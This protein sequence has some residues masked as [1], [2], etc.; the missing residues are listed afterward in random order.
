MLLHQPTVDALIDSMTPSADEVQSRKDVLEFSEQDSLLLKELGPL[1]APLESAF[2]DSLSQHLDSHPEMAATLSNPEQLSQ[3]KQKQQEYFKK[4]F[5]GDYGPD[6]IKSRL[7]VGVSYQQIG[8]EPRW[9]LGAYNKY[10]SLVLPEVMRLVGNDAE[11]FLAYSKAITKIAMFDSELSLSAYFHADHEMLRLLAQVFESNLEAVIIADVKG[12][13]LHVNKSVAKITG[14]ASD[15]LIGTP[16]QNLLA[17]LEPTLYQDLW[18]TV[19]GGGQWQG[20]IWLKNKQG[21]D[22]LAWMNMNAVKDAA[23]KVT[24]VIAEFSDITA[25][26]QTQ[27]ALAQRTEELANSNRELE[28]FAYVASHDLQEPLRM[29]ASYTQ[30]LARRYKDKLDQDA[31][32]FIGY[33]VDG[34]T[35]MQ[36]LI[37]D[38]LT[39]SRIGTHGKQMETCETSVALERAVSNLRLAI[40]ESGAVVTRDPMPRLDADVSQ[41]TQLFQNLIGNGIKFR[42]DTSP[43]I[44]VGAEKKEGE[45]L[46]SVRDNGIGIA[47]DFFERIFIIFQRLHGKHEYPGTGIG[48]SVCKKIVER[49]GGRIWIESEVGKGAVF[50]FTL[51]IHHG[52]RKHHGE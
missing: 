11:R 22:Y 2:A 33:A 16:M 4:V 24:Q 46:F 48:L 52:E 32:E 28:Q 35:R 19:I 41:L 44:H 10:L 12:R 20:E 7:Q 47:P 31:N 21:D 34:A 1:L 6:Y 29:V 9:Y 51:P 8:L 36:A 37:I 5:A 18:N 42:G 27:E 13:M 45:W 30:L 43:I 14:Y 39:M 26:K 17:E 15:A 38:L 49:H 23:G 3:L 25:F 40:E 50:Y